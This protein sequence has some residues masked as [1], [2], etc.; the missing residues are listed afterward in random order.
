MAGMA[1]A[2]LIGVIGVL[3][4]FVV[5]MSRDSKDED[6]AR[7]RREAEDSKKRR[8]GRGAL[9]RMQR[10]AEGRAGAEAAGG[11]AEGGGSDDEV[12]DAAREARRQERRAQQAAD[13]QARLDKELARKEKQSAYNAK[14]QERERAFA[15]KEAEQRKIKEEKEQKENEELDKWKELFAVDAEGEDDA[16]PAEAGALERFVNFVKVR[17]AVQLEDLAAQFRLKTQVAIDRL[18]DLERMG[19]LQGI[20]D[21]RGKFIYISDDEMKEVAAWLQKKG[22]I[23][24]SEL[25]AACNRI[26]RLNP[27]KA[28]ADDDPPSTAPGSI[29]AGAAGKEEGRASASAAG[30][31]EASRE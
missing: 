15:K 19:R 31:S 14:Q 28:K 24:R 3:I 30:C 29:T 6:A 26:V 23:N 13:R 11:G 9:E 7:R 4:F 2:V 5:R 8:R 16:D 17:K 10:Q 18:H 21:D 22:R 20:F 12:V 1:L 25:V 27:N